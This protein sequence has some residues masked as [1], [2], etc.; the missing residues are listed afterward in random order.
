MTSVLRNGIWTDVYK[1]L[2][3]GYM[4]KGQCTTHKSTSFK[5]KVLQVVESGTHRVRVAVAAWSSVLQVPVALLRHLGKEVKKSSKIRSKTG[6]N[7]TGKI[8]TST[9]LSGNSD[10][11]APVGNAGREVVDGGSLVSSGQPSLVVLAWG[12][13]SSNNRSPSG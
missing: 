2:P 7:R 4:Q 3:H 10:A 12:E 5:Q 6:K 11:A 8:E 9:D 13:K 1:Y